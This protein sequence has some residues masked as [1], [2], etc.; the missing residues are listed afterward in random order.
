MGVNI[1]L[2]FRLTLLQRPLGTIQPQRLPRNPV[3]CSNFFIFKII[4]LVSNRPFFL[5]LKPVSGLPL[6]H[7]LIILHHIFSA[8]RNDIISLEPNRWLAFQRIIGFICKSLGCT[9][10]SDLLFDNTATCVCGVNT[11]PFSAMNLI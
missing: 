6:W 4:N 3:C 11:R 7:P 10:G 2:K 5:F 9:L 1:D 8:L